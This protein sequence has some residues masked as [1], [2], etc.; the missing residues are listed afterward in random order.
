MF[1]VFAENKLPVM[2]TNATSNTVLKWKSSEVVADCYKKLFKEAPSYMDR[3]LDKVYGTDPDKR[4]NVQI[5]FAVV[6]VEYILNPQKER[7]KISEELLERRIERYMV[8]FHK[9]AK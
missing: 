1:N 2:N 6:L 3:I 4:S 5:A 8:C 7:I 9:Y